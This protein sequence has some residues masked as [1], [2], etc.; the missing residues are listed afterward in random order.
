MLIKIDIGLHFAHFTNILINIHVIQSMTKVIVQGRF[1]F[2]FPSVSVIVGWSGGCVI[3]TG[4]V[5][6]RSGSDVIK[7][8]PVDSM[9]IITL[10]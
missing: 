10:V 8:C 6:G 4:R 9:T 2:K 3:D 1:G 5:L 7:V